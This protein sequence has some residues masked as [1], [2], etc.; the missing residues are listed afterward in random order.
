MKRHKISFKFAFTLA[1]VLTVL[2]IVGLIA[3][4][5]IPSMLLNTQKE[6]Y[7]ASLKKV[8]STWDNALTSMAD[9]NGA[10]GDLKS[11][12]IFIAGIADTAA[13]KI[14]MGD[15]IAKYFKVSK[16]CQ[17]STG[18][19]SSTVAPNYD[20]SGTKSAIAVSGF[21]YSFVTTDGMSVVIHPA[22]SVNCASPEA[23]TSNAKGPAKNRCAIVYIDVNGLKPP[24]FMG[25]DVFKMLIVNGTGPQLTASGIRG[26][27][28]QYGSDLYYKTT[29][30][31]NTNKNGDS[32]AAR[33]IEEGWQM[34]Y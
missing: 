34:N 29:G 9:D 16:N 19:V 27:A 17:L 7:V 31:C 30:N 3:T 12:G 28:S 15:S 22:D 14:Q 11:S 6:H 4:I 25:R 13:L 10:N 18:C 2:G 1:E 26:D 24:N 21:D 20:G 5:T 23:T 8:V 33:I 32:C